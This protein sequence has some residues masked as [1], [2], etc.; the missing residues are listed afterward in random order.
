[1][2]IEKSFVC[3]T[4]RELQSVEENVFEMVNALVYATSRMLNVSKNIDN[5]QGMGIVHTIINDYKDLK[6]DQLVYLFKQGQKGIYGPHYNKF[7]IETVVTWINGFYVSDEYNTFLE[8]RHKQPVGKVELTDEQK[9]GWK[10]LNDNYKKFQEEHLRKK[11]EP[12]KLEQVPFEVLE[13]RLSPVIVTL[14]DIEINYWLSEYK[15]QGNE[16]MV[17]LINNELKKREKNDK[18]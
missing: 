12:I 15:L 16:D 14:N 11:Y 5:F 2:T 3:Q 1:M 17:K 13:K 4:I 9:L 8:N 6:I 18:I 7:D 10:Q